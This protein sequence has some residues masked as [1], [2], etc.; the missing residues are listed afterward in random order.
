M[1]REQR[2]LQDLIRGRQ[3]GGFVGRQGQV[4]QYQENLGYPVNDVRRRFLF[5]IHGDAGVGKTYLTK[6]LQQVA[7]DG[8]ALT[9]YIDETRE[10]VTAVMS[11][12]A[13]QFGQKRI[14]LS[15]FQKRADSYRQRRQ[16]LEAD[17]DAPDGMA[18][19]LTKTAVTIGIHAARDVPIAG[20]ILAPVDP[21]LAA[22][23]LNQARKYLARKLR[24][25]ADVRL[26]LSPADEL[27]RV[28]VADLT[29]TTAARTVAL[30]FDTFERTAPFLDQWLRDLYAGRYGDLPGELITTI[31]GQFPLNPNLWGDYLP[32][33][34][35]FSLQ[36]FSEAE[37]RQ[38]LASKNITDEPTI[39]VIL[40]LSGRLPMW[41]A[42]LAE[43][44]PEDAADIGDPAGD[45]VE[46]F[47]KWEDD[48][49][50]R[51]VAVTAALPRTINQDVLGVITNIDK[52]R[53]L[54]A[55]LCGRPFVTR[56]AESWTYHEV[57]RA[58]MLRL[59]RAQSPRQWREN[60]NLLARAN[61]Q[62]ASEHAEGA[63]QTW[64]NAD[65]VAYTIDETY[66]LLCADPVSNLPQALAAAVRAAESSIGRARQWAEILSDA[67]RDADRP[68]LQGWGQRLLDGIKDTD[69][70]G[71]LTCL[72]NEAS[73]EVVPLVI[74]LRQRGVC[75]VLAERYEEAIADFT[76]HRAR[77]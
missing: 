60:H 52:S 65:W 11:S 63:K 43:A 2:S 59:Q 9:A 26:L 34:A 74:A 23:Q 6:Q 35:D 39:D 27:T 46:R 22:E 12:I 47:L 70:T 21:A 13:E 5:N 25:H 3:Q 19:F 36:S 66:H 57:V 62:W 16:E 58:A 45:A 1:T 31:S 33:I 73:L 61:A 7:Y 30:F 55:W 49:K 18:T 20:S 10:D 4:V 64:S 17:P 53:E 24:S 41:L 40:T 32:V 76:R 37:A 72:I 15:E 77:P 29:R 42:T 56:Q 69:L 8:G 50:R 51:A 71:Y 44:R 68:V 54:F 28:F 67:G 38:F 48:P 75:Y 14:R